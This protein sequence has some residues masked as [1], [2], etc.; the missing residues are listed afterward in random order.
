MD[1]CKSIWYLL[2]RNYE[3]HCSGLNETHSEGYRQN[4]EALDSVS[5]FHTYCDSKEELTA[6]I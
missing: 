4:F 6:M 5:E 2:W 3:F 1:D